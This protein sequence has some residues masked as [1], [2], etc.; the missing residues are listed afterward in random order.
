MAKDATKMH[1]EM[2]KQG[3]KFQDL[4]VYTEDGDMKGIFITY[5]RAAAP[6]AAP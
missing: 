6:S 2:A 1:V 4:E 5:V 3:W